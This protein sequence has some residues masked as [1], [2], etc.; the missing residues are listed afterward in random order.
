[1][2]LDKYSKEELT[3]FEQLIGRLMLDSVYDENFKR[4]HPNETAENRWSLTNPRN[5]QVVGKHLQTESGSSFESER[6]VWLRWGFVEN[7]TGTGRYTDNIWLLGTHHIRDWMTSYLAKGD[8]QP[9]LCHIMGLFLGMGLD[10]EPDNIL[11]LPVYGMIPT[12]QK[13]FRLSREMKGKHPITRAP[14]FYKSEMDLFVAAGY[15][16]K[17]D[18]HYQWTMKIGYEMFFAVHWNN[19]F[20]SIDDLENKQTFYTL[21]SDEA[22]K[23]WNEIPHELKIKVFDGHP[24]E[25]SE[26]YFILLCRHWDKSKQVWRLQSAESAE[27]DQRAYRMMADYLADGGFL[28][29][30]DLWSTFFRNND[31]SPF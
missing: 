7:T 19:S 29:S 2:A 14:N 13:P 24:H 9:H 12:T 28:G 5:F 22:E 11:K 15:A 27:D 18:D 30:D 16:R 8:P 23:I 20:R 31:R 3:L 1:M 6:D 21:I 25:M 17:I 4:I 26:K 10:L